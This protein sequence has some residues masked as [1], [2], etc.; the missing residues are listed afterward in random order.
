MQWFMSGAD[1]IENTVPYLMTIV[2]IFT[3]LFAMVLFYY[4]QVYYR[5]SAILVVTILPY[6]IYVKLIREV[7][8]GYVMLAIILN[9]A[10]FLINTRKQRDKGKRIIGYHSGLVS[11]LL[12]ALCFVMIALVIPKSDT[13]K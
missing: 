3:L 8:I 7:G 2:V 6:I 4:T 12:Y 10:A 1:T 5:T 9:V 11:V 13:T